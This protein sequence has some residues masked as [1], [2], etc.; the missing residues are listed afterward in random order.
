MVSR[1]ADGTNHTNSELIG[2]SNGTTDKFSIHVSFE[3]QVW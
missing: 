3:L 2:V 1:V